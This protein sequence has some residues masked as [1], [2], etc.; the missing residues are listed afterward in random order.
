MLSRSGVATER[1]IPEK[2]GGGV[3]AFGTIRWGVRMD[4]LA[5][6]TSGGR[7][8][9]Y[10]YLKVLN[11]SL[12]RRARKR[13]VAARARVVEDATLWLADAFHILRQEAGQ[14]PEL[15]PRFCALYM[16]RMP[17]GGT[18]AHDDLEAAGGARRA[19]ST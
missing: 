10:F 15:S 8:E 17:D 19:A 16:S 3:Q 9:T 6:R 13:A 5:T 7:Y 2:L 12:S 14:P 18:Q 4:A 11:S 1:K